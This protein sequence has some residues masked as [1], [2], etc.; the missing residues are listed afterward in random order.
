M[1]DFST[2]ETKFIS[3]PDP[4]TISELSALLNDNDLTYESDLDD[5]V[6]VRDQGSIIGTGSISGN[7]LKC[8]AV[9]KDYKNKNVSGHIITKLVKQAYLR[10]NT[11]LFLFTKPENIKKFSTM[12]FYPLYEVPEKVVL[13]ENTPSGFDEYI[14]SLK[15]ETKSIV[16]GSYEGKIASIVLNCNPITNGHLYLIKKAAEESDWLHIF[17][18]SEDKSV[19]PFDVRFK[20]VKEAVASF[21]NI[22]IHSGGRYI[23]SNA[24]FPSYFIKDSKQIINIHAQLDLGLFSEKIA[25]ALSIN[26][27]YA[28]DEP[29]CPVTSNYN[30]FMKEI[31]PKRGIDFHIIK[32]LETEGE[33][34]SASKVRK[35]MAERNFEGIRKI[36]PKTTYDFLLTREGENIIRRLGEQ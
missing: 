6:V 36:V 17:V 33:P 31:L 25:P 30:R 8:I 29:L 5:T 16:T 32:R 21:K 12:G 22:I 28:G 24:T 35:Y 9:N 14:A 13:M 26:A 15:R 10:G 18:V 4:S 34:V 2:F 7:V 20:L 27:R 11:E 1:S 19:F 23:I 3:E